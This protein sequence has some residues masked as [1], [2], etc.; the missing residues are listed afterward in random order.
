MNG[1]ATT[2]PEA[3]MKVAQLLEMNF[4]P[5]CEAW[6]QTR[7]P[8][9]SAGTHKDYRKN[10]LTLTR[11]F[12]KYKLTEIDGDLIREFQLERGEDV[13]YKTGLKVGPN[14][15]NKETG[16]LCQI[17]K[18]V[19]RPVLDYQP[20]PQPDSEVG[21]ALE[22]EECE[23][24]F[25][26]AAENPDWEGVYLFALIS[27]NTSAGPKEC[28]SLQ[29]KDVNIPQRI[30]FI[31]GT[32]NVHRKRDIPLNE[33]ALEAVIRA[34]ARANRLGSTQPDH[35]LFPFKYFKKAEGYDPTRRKI[36][37]HQ[38]WRN[39]TERAGLKGLRMYDLRHTCIT[40]LCENPNVSEQA[41]ESIAGHVTAKMKKKYCH[42][43]IEVKRQAV[44]SM[45]HRKVAHMK[46]QPRSVDLDI[47]A[48]V[49]R[50]LQKILKDKGFAS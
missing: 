19:G 2:C 46:K 34:V 27:I 16:L 37:Y 15:I 32:K 9:I 13:Y 29:L 31:P 26:I 45:V 38:M 28:L 7:R 22:P 44:E 40:R 5:A 42:L 12:A 48:E 25:R 4:Q 10:I 17:L 3:L 11:W 41:I 39:L 6:L 18:R 14:S 47:E 35:Y 43:R 50:R 8:Y 20:L 23:R 33:E 49:E 24:L 36:S 30:I 21:R 1:M